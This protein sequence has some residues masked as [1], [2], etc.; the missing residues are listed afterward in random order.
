[1]RSLS[2]SHVSSRPQPK[3]IPWVLLLVLID[4]LFQLTLEVL[5]Q[6]LNYL[7]ALGVPIYPPSLSK[8]F[9]QVVL[10]L[11]LELLFVQLLLSQLLNY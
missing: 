6:A 7:L 9:L 8:Q 3:L 2:V 4:G 5:L 11:V 1:M 10:Q